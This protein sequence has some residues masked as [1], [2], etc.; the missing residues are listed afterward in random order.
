MKASAVLALLP[1][2]IAAPAKRD[3]PAP[4]IVPRGVQVVEGKYIVKFKDEF[5]AQHVESAVTS[6]SADAEHLFSE[7]F[8]GFAASLTPQEVEN[9]RHDPSVSR[10]PHTTKCVARCIDP[11]G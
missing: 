3:S 7:L 11:L 9:L 2:A 8:N 5:K 6:I 1:L 10:I 4:L